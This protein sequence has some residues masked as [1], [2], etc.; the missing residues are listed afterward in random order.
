MCVSINMN[1][2]KKKRIFWD[3]VEFGSTI[4]KTEE[5]EEEVKK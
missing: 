5:K 4:R 1:K 2:M 3:R